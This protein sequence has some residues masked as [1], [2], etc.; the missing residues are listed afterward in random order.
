MLPKTQFQC[1]NLKSRTRI[2]LGISI[3]YFRSLFHRFR[4]TKYMHIYVKKEKMSNHV[5]LKM[6]KN[7]LLSWHPDWETHTFLHSRTRTTRQR[8]RSGWG[9][10][11]AP[12]TRKRNREQ[13][14]AEL[15]LRFLRL[16]INFRRWWK[17]VYQNDVCPTLSYLHIDIRMYR[18]VENCWRDGA[19]RGK[20]AGRSDEQTN[21]V[22]SRLRIPSPFY[23]EM[24]REK[25]SFSALVYICTFLV[26]IY[27]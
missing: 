16:R 1:S 3:C 22:V 4:S 23:G 14:R 27:W 2:S 10:A 13:G 8:K 18:D 6:I 25:A 21:R 9:V 15:R 26:L 5:A 20:W 17:F 19:C 24:I 7:V 12:A 11:Q